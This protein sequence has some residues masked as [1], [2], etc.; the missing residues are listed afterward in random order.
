MIFCLLFFTLP[1]QATGVVWVGLEDSLHFFTKF[2]DFNKFF[3]L[4][5]QSDLDSSKVYFVRTDN[6]LSTPTSPTL[7]SVSLSDEPGW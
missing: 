1:D 5:V 4:L 7:D 2:I 6:E 3:F